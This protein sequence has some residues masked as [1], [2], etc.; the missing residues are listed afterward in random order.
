MKSELTNRLKLAAINST[1][2]KHRAFTLAFVGI[3]FLK[4][5]CCW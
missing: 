3:P 4:P 2:S 5:P 1:S